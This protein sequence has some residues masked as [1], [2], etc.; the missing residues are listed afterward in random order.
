M[1]NYKQF[2]Q[3]R[4]ENCHFNEPV[5]DEEILSLENFL[6][7]PIGERYKQL[8]LEFN[9]FQNQ[10]GTRLLFSVE[11]AIETTKEMWDK[12]N[13]WSEFCLPF[14][15]MYFMGEV[16]NGDLFFFPIIKNELVDWKIYLWDHEEDSRNLVGF[17]LQT[18]LS[19]IFYEPDGLYKLAVR[20]IH[21]GVLICLESNRRRLMA[22][23][24]DD[25]ILWNEYVYDGI[26]P[27]AFGSFPDVGSVSFEGN[28]VHLIFTSGKEKIFDL[29][30]GK[31]EFDL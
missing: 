3:S 26:S 1:T 31:S 30:T 24:K 20:D 19:K 11:E 29:M 25:E 22:I 9:G 16:G 14:Q 18:F 23:S 2:I 10:T 13:G 6:G 4:D 28:K 8:L 5:T 17:H 27:N 7:F 12:K 15:A 21:S